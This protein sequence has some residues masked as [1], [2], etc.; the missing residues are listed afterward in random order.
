[1]AVWLAWQCEEVRNSVLTSLPVFGD[2]V[3]YELARVTSHA[4][5]LYEQGDCGQVPENCCFPQDLANTWFLPTS[6]LFGLVFLGLFLG[7][8]VWKSMADAVNGV[9]VAVAAAIELLQCFH[10]VCYSN[11][12]TWLHVSSQFGLF[13]KQ[14]CTKPGVECPVALFIGL[15]LLCPRDVGTILV[16]PWDTN[17][18]CVFC[19]K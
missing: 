12:F 1:M 3:V 9:L 15:C 5:P 19:G 13:N 6:L 2:H 10:E 4:A 17:P 16:A 14:Y 11:D 8:L 7:I 18:V